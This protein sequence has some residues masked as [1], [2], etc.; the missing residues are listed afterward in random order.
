MSAQPTTYTD[1]Y[2]YSIQANDMSEKQDKIKENSARRFYNTALWYD[3]YRN[4]TS[5][6]VLKKN[7]LFPYQAVNGFIYFQMKNFAQF[8]DIE[9]TS[10]KSR[11]KYKY[12]LAVNTP[13]GM[14][15]ISFTAIP[16]E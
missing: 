13:N 12:T 7:T 3:I 1:D 2:G 9:N 10:E 8:T 11:S 14:K 4:S 5:A 6:S 15:N 16:G